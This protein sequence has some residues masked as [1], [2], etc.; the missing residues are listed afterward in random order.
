[1]NYLIKQCFN[2]KNCH[3]KLGLDSSD[4]TYV[5]CYN[6]GVVE[7]LKEYK[8]VDHVLC[9]PFCAGVLDTRL[10]Q[11]DGLYPAGSSSGAVTQLEK[12]NLKTA[13]VTDTGGSTI[14]PAARANMYGFKP[15][16]GRIT[17]YGLVP[18]CSNLD[19]VSILS[20]DLHELI[21]YF[22]VLDVHDSRDLTNITIK[23]RE[24]STKSLDIKVS[25][26]LFS[27]DQLNTLKAVFP[28]LIEEKLEIIEDQVI[29]AYWFVLCPDLF[30]N[31]CRF[32][33][34]H[35]KVPDSNIVPYFNMKNIKEI[36]TKNIPL[37]V[38]S[39][40]VLGSYLI[41]KGIF[42]ET[43]I[44]KFISKYKEKLGNSLW[45]T[46]V[47]KNLRNNKLNSTPYCALN[48]LLYRPSITIPVPFPEG[49]QI[50]GPQNSDYLLLNTVKGI[51][52]QH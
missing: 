19:T 3:V 42:K 33:G 47:A 24:F 2:V 25:S 38:K 22:H 23:Q 12:T 9:S 52:L 27:Q 45:I 10:V 48:N 36:R 13:I 7:L 8:L 26:N 34:I 18:L 1:M 29:G 43:L 31:M 28:N 20:K 5:S 32:N 6:S 35:Y 11:K 37:E 17:R 51:E 21:E 44:E 46:P 39:R 4:L 30:S 40:M 49:I 14:C 41:N 15:S 50:S 16:Y